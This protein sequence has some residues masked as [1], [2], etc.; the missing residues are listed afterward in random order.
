MGVTSQVIY[1][2]IPSM[3]LSSSAANVNVNLTVAHFELESSS[4][5]SSVGLLN[6]LSL[7]FCE[8]GLI[9][10]SGGQTQV[11]SCVFYKVGNE[12]A[13]VRGWLIPNLTPL[14]V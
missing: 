8:I 3:K 1:P 2:S 10:G 11:E 9:A 4:T 6:A 12:L 5:A 14:N 13:A 7:H